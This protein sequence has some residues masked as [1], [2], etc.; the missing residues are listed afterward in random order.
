[1]SSLEETRPAW[2]DDEKVANRRGESSL[3]VPA[4]LFYLRTL[5]IRLLF[6]VEHLPFGV[7]AKDVCASNSDT[8]Y[9]LSCPTLLQQPGDA[10]NMLAK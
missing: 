7:A 9:L 2:T 8:V 1:M 4:F 5:P 6:S 10:C 3:C